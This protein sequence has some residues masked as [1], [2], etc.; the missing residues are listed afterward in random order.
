ML[1]GLSHTFLIIIK[2]LVLVIFSPLM[3]SPILVC[4]KA[5]CLV[6]LSSLLLSM[7]YPLLCLLILMSSADDTAIY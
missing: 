6:L 1:L 7:I 5:W 2:L 4:L 3:V